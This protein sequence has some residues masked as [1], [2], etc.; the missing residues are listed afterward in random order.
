MQK[1]WGFIKVLAVSLVMCASWA[2]KS[3]ANVAKD[4]KQKS[5]SLVEK[6]QTV[7]NDSITLNEAAKIS[8]DTAAFN[9]AR[10]KEK[11]FYACCQLEDFRAKNYD[12]GFGNRTIG[13]GFCYDANGKKVTR[14]TP[15]FKS[16]EQVKAN[17]DYFY[18][19]FN[20]ELAKRIHLEK[21]SEDQRVALF[22]MY[23]Q[24]G[25]VSFSQIQD[26]LNAYLDN[27]CAETEQVLPGYVKKLSPEEEEKAKDKNVDGRVDRRAFEYR[28][29][30]GKIKLSLGTKGSEKDENVFYVKEAKLGGT[31]RTWYISDSE[32]FC[33]KLNNVESTKRMNPTDTINNE[34]KK[35]AN[36]RQPVYN[37]KR[38]QTKG[39]R[40]YVARSRTC[41]GK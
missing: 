36:D 32:K 18:K 33:E 34:I 30:T 35:H 16:M 21:A 19:Q 17:F 2:A 9:E 38:Y 23:Y 26:K 40:R 3:K 27:P 29:F 20:K 28:L 41:R 37:K 4:I 7:L 6:T 1:D 24:R 14:N 8:D 39:V 12:D 10:Y 13:I 15:T 22:L 25:P 31:Y 11:T 5:D